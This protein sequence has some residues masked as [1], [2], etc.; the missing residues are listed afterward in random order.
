MTIFR[1]LTFDC[2][3]LAAAGYGVGVRMLELVSFRE[4]GTKRETR[5]SKTVLLPGSPFANYS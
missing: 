5:V 4:R 1:N 3:Q 2:K